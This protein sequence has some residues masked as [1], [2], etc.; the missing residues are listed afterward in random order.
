VQLSIQRRP[1]AKGATLSTWYLDGQ[2]EC[3]GC[4]D[5]VRGPAEKKVH[6]QSAI[7]AGT[8]PVIINR[9]ERFSRIAKKDVFLPLLVDVPGYAGVR[10]HPG[11]NPSQT[12]GCLLPGTAIGPDGASVAYSQAAFR[13]LFGK[14]QAALERGETIKLTIR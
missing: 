2:L 9:S 6:G 12:E 3:Y 13:T 14:M 1:S 10:I 8:Y 5:V 7:P 4:E 11:N